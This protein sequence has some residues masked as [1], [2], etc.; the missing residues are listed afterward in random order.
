MLLARQLYVK[1]KKKQQQKQPQWLLNS[2]IKAISSIY[3][4]FLSFGAG[5]KMHKTL[6][7]PYFQP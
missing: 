4:Y 3:S 1:K 7:L 2:R 5:T 6:L